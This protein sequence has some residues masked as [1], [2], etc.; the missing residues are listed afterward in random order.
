ME[1]KVGSSAV[2]SPIEDGDRSPPNDQ[3]DGEDQHQHDLRHE[4]TQGAQRRAPDCAAGFHHA[5][6]HMFDQPADHGHHV[7]R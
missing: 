1:V 7:A 2:P 3:P 6:R 5:T 4:S